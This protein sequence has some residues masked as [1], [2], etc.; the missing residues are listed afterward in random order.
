MA[1][2]E[3][4]RKIVAEISAI[5][6][7][8]QRSILAARLKMVTVERERKIVAEEGSRL[9][10]EE[11]TRI[12]QAA[13]GG[14]KSQTEFGSKHDS[15]DHSLNSNIANRRG[16]QSYLEQLSSGS[17]TPLQSFSPTSSAAPTSSLNRPSIPII[18]LNSD[19]IVFEGVETGPPFALPEAEIRAIEKAIE[20]DVDKYEA[21]FEFSVQLKAEK[22]AEEQINGY[23]ANGA[24]VGGFQQPNS[25]P[26]HPASQTSSPD[27]SAKATVTSAT[28]TSTYSLVKKSTT[29]SSYTTMDGPELLAMEK[30][31]EAEVENHSE[32]DGPV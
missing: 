6:E 29:T 26:T 18:N 20:A 4:G 19:S 30:S 1:T 2:V 8:N 32:P 31:A 14:M 21:P 3:R 5:A 9:L 25:E 16:S 24:H 15:S 10:A 17:S 22:K 13:D 23:N 28:F 11:E 27:R 7:M 12:L